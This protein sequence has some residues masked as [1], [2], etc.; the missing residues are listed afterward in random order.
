MNQLTRMATKERTM[1]K[2]KRSQM[3][4]LTGFCHSMD[5]PQS[6]RRMMPLTHL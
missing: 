3:S 4:S 1:V 2:A 6:P 5:W